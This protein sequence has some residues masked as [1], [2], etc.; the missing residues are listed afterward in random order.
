[1]CVCTYGGD[2]VT[3]ASPEFFKKQSLQKNTQ[4]TGMPEVEKFGG[5]SS[6]WWEAFVQMAKWIEWMSGHN[7]CC[8]APSPH[9][10]NDCD[11]YER[12]TCVK[13]KH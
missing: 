6:N 11:L 4:N 9:S 13:H 3:L 12:N 2:Q 8:S 5:A 7:D 1:M 10:F